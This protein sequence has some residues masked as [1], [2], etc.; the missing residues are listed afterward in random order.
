MID[1]LLP[2]LTGR[3][4]VGH[5]ASPEQLALAESALGDLAIDDHLQFLAE[6]GG[7]EGTSATLGHVRL[8]DA[9]DLA[10]MNEGYCVAEFLTDVVLIGTDGGDEAFGLAMRNGAVRVIQ[11]PFIPMDDESVRLL[12]ES[13]RDFLRLI[14]GA[15][16]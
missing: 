7:L 14:V 3:F 13:F 1:D 9:D 10:L 11:V 4:Q 6:V 5:Q 8:W 16:E 2:L 15:G 12:A